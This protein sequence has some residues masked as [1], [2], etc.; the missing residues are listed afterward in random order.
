MDEKTFDEEFSVKDSEE[1]IEM[2]TKMIVENAKLQVGT[3]KK[4]RHKQQV[5]IIDNIPLQFSG[6]NVGLLSQASQVRFLSEGH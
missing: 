4:K 5:V 3:S 1:R 2:I 6:Q